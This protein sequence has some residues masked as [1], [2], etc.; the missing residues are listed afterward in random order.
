MG[1][2]EADLQEVIDLIRAIGDT[3]TGLII[4]E[5]V[6]EVVKQLAQRAIV[7]NWGRHFAE[8][9]P[10]SVA[11]DERVREVYF[12]V[13]D[14][15]A[16]TFA[17]REAPLIRSGQGLKLRNAV[18]RRGQH[19]ALD[20]FEINV[21]SEAVTAILG[22]N[23]AACSMMNVRRLLMRSIMD[24]ISGANLLVSSGFV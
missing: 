14:P 2:S 7:L 19:L 20:G 12:G 17:R 16:I 8:G 15:Q 4:V 9:T 6:Q 10:D 5:H 13:R 21:P 23:G 11:N 3:G 18:V 1:L 22:P 24:G